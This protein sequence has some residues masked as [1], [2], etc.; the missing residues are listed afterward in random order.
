MKKFLSLFCLAGLLTAPLVAQAPQDLTGNW[1]GTLKT[2]NKDLRIIVKVEKSDDGKLK[3]TMY[4]I[5][6]TPQPF[7]SSGFSFQNGELKFLIAMIGGSYTGK[8]SADGKTV[9]GSWTQGDKPM[10]LNFVHATKDIAWDIPAPQPPPKNIPA[11]ADPSFEVATIKPNDKNA[12]Q[13]QGLWVDGTR[14]HTRASSVVD[15]ICFAYDVQARQITSAPD[16]ADKDRVDIDAKQDIEGLPSPV[17][18]RNMIKKLLADR[19]A[20]TFHHEKKEM[21][22][23]VLRVAKGGFKGEVS[24]A[25]LP[26]PGIGFRPGKEGVLLPLNNVNMTDVSTFLQSAVLDRP[27]VDQT[28]LSGRYNFIIKFWPDEEMF[29][30]HPP[31]PK[32]KPEGVETAP[33]LFEALQTDNGLK[34]TPEKTQVDV[35]AIDHVEKPSAN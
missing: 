11:D 3:G 15:L 7:P 35:I 6:Q 16:W 31:V 27:V 28:G 20:L 32:E 25:K 22:A 19:Y 13:M 18:L 26:L 30:G 23:F 33:S 10:D 34:L 24:N 9:N 4:S 29:N 21:S 8:L 1:Q 17:Q 12:T 14:F 2:P 5:D